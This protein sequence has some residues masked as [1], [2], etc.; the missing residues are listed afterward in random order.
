MSFQ[1]DLNLGISPIKQKVSQVLQFLMNYLKN[2]VEAMKR[3]PDWDWPTLLVLNSACAAAS[4]AL[5]GII[6]LKLQV[7]IAGLIFFPVTST[8]GVLILTAFFHYTF[9]FFFHKELNF[10]TLFT[11]V[12]LALLPFFALMTLSGLIPPISIVGFAASSILFIVGFREYS[13]IETKVIA[14]IVGGLYLAF[15]LMWI[16]NMIA[17]QTETKKYKELATPDSY[18]MLNNEFKKED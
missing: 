13:K 17:S 6:S 15:I 8:V 1:E 18:Q 12:V 7:F 11:I 9:L 2:P 16:I 5:S 3:L 14:R 10:K 4:G